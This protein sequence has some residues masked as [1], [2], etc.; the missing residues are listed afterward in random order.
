[1][2]KRIFRSIAAA[3]L[4]V[5]AAVLVAVTGVLYTYFS[6][7]QRQQL[8]L[9]TALA[10]QGVAA[11]GT[12][13]F[14]GLGAM[15]CRITWIAADGTVLCDTAADAAQMENHLD[16][17]EVSVALKS[18]WGESSR[19]SDTLLQQLYYAAQ[20]L[21]DGSVV[22][23][24]CA[25]SS[26]FSLLLELLRPVL[27]VVV[28]ALALSLLLA[29]R[30]AAR[31]VEP[32]NHLDLDDPL[33]NENCDELT[34]LLR[35]IHLQQQQLKKQSEALYRRQEEFDAVTSSMNEGLVLLDAHGAILSINGAAQRILDTE[36]ECQGKDLL[37]LNR[38]LVL[39]ELLETA[40]SGQH[41]ERELTLR[42]REYQ[43][44]TTPVFYGGAVSGAVLLIFDV[45]E[46]RSAQRM[47]REF[48]A[49]VSHELR[50]PLHTISGCA[51][52]LC[53]G[54]VKPEDVGEFHEKLYAES[55][56]MICLVEDIINLSRLDEGA[57][58]MPRQ[59]VDLYALA[60]GSVD[61][62]SD[63]AEKAGVTV[64]LTGESAPLTGVPQLLGGIVTNL[65][66]NAIKYNRP[67]G[68]VDVSVENGEDTV[69]LRVADTGIG[70]PP[71]HR[72][73]VFERFYRVDKSRSKAVG[74]TGLGLS[75]VKH[76]AL[77]HHAKLE[78]DSAVGVGTTITVRFP[79]ESGE[80]AQ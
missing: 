9:D 35:R 23:L 11:G 41:G 61:A 68:R 8:R 4:A 56:R 66:D 37:T 34:P 52:L 50:T 7:V 54:L 59:T 77:I 76:A 19:Y 58:D 33:A 47:R 44:D 80:K 53:N 74:G 29:R 24:S 22:R 15:D 1:M 45:T 75:I 60:R 62:L 55:Q 65:C 17:Q 48:T 16:R 26:V 2:T 46:K 63:A 25:Q 12:D 3:A 20:R 5:L 21:P 49:N 27:L 40:L 57:Q 69:T 31:V 67:Q 64:T 18:G 43:L 38:S 28:L 71:E 10:A 13:Y 42:G 70:I 39:Q 79:K 51:E 36:E 6:H 30:L 72:S 78:L 32:L 14:A 73:R